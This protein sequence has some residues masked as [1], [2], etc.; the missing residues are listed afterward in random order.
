MIQAEIDA[1]AEL[2]DF[3]RFN[4]KYALELEQ[5]QPL[6]VDISTNSMVYRGLEVNWAPPMPHWSRWGTGGSQWSLV[7]VPPQGFVAAVSPF[8]FTAIGGNLA[9]APALMVSA[10]GQG[11]GTGQGT[12]QARERLGQGSQPSG[13]AGLGW[14]R[15]ELNWGCSAVP[16][17]H[18]L[19]SL[20]Q[21]SIGL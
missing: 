12:G 19:D 2:I 9:G 21:S 15:R 10:G 11:R 14:A 1:A 20:T 4:A 13:S 16:Q 5:S 18:L 6:S 8:N 7:P 3:F 17:T